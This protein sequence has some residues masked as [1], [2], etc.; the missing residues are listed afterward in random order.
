V[1]PRIPEASASQD[2]GSTP[3]FR[4]NAFISYS[5][6]VDGKLA[7]AL[8][9]A[10]QRFAKPWYR[11]RGLR[12]FRDD[13]SLS[14]SPALWSSI[15]QALDASEFFV[16]LASPEAAQSR[17][18][19]KE[20]EYWREHKARDH[21]LV[22]LTDGEIVWDETCRSFR[23]DETSLPRAIDGVFG[24][25]PR[26][27]D[28]RWARKEEHL[29]LRD[30]RFRNDIAD[31]AATLH[32]WSKDEILGEDVRQHRRTLRIA[33][34][35]MILLAALLVTAVLGGLL[36]V[37]QRNQAQ[38]ERDVASSR[39]L[40][41]Q[42]VSD[43]DDSLPR[44]LL[45]SLEA[46]RVRDTTEARSA[47][48]TALQRPTP[49]LVGFLEGHLDSVTTIDF[50]AD[51]RLFAAGAA[52]GTIRLW[53][54]ARRQPVGPVIPAHSLGVESVAFSPDGKI[55]A[56]AGDLTIKLWDVSSHRK[57]GSPLIDQ[58]EGIE[59]LAFRPDGKTLVSAGDD[60]AIRFW[61]VA[62][63]RQLGAPLRG[64]REGV[65]TVAFSPDGRT[66]ASAGFDGTVRM[67]DVARRRQA[68]PAL[69][70]HRSIVVGVAFSPDGT[71][72]AS[73][74]GDDTVRLWDV[75]RRRQLGKPLARLSEGVSSVAF[76]PDG[77]RLAAGGDSGTIMVWDV[78]Q[79][80]LLVT[81]VSPPG[82]HSVS[83]SAD[84]KTIASA[85]LSPTI[86]L[87]SVDRPRRLGSRLIGHRDLI[88]GVAFSP[89]GD[90]LA[91]SSSDHRIRFWD[92]QRARPLGKPV[93][94]SDH[95][96][97]VR[98]VAFMPNGNSLMSAGDP[99]TIR[100]WDVE[101]QRPAGAPLMVGVETFEGFAFSSDRSR[102]AYSTGF[103]GIS[104]WDVARRRRV[105]APLPSGCPELVSVLAFS[106]D[107]E[108][109]VSGCDT[110]EIRFWDLVHHRQLG[111]PTTGHREG[112]HSL[113]FSPDGKTL[114]S[115]STDRTIRFW[116]VAERRQVGAPLVEHRDWINGLAFSPDG[117]LLA[118]GGSDSMIRLWDV[119]RRQTLGLPLVGHPAPVANVVFSPDGTK[120]ASFSND[121][122]IILWD[123]DLRSWIN[124]A[125]T[126]ASRNLTQ[127][128]W[129]RFVGSSRP[130]ERTCQ[131][132]PAG[133]GAPA[134]A[135]SAPVHATGQ[136]VQEPPAPPSR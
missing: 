124:H 136:G 84:G 45:L 55:I 70:G 63:R 125:C 110:G 121:S 44:A 112:V 30:A 77:K 67:W 12:V 91:S 116:D 118:S 64:D 52:D 59:D 15:V 71:K 97:V 29:T 11:L 65:M 82:A 8:Q 35:A 98:D 21:M 40:A 27:T 53:D 111:T 81:L 92:V 89:M 48:L 80:R 24:E 66:L 37:N 61:N 132:H 107:A 28:L 46:L 42:A 76:S 96:L 2:V 31:I 103:E 4:Y 113:T 109:L 58:Q 134:D 41:A 101:R 18:V 56:S 135:P 26:Y 123:L 86:K 100:R 78:T 102:I 16:L 19:G 94:I 47:L 62:R 119:E 130:Y 57:I 23:W 104:V 115:G 39:Y 83:F 13:A 7:P 33:G 38:A 5:R 108:T 14:A 131:D 129:E 128:E 3:K 72:V 114:V 10:L 126:L 51:G 133:V 74:G 117:T 50:S 106:P 95:D 69:E 17:W 87:W 122:T 60:G 127:E 85:G 73:V 105:G 93:R 43:V 79:R 1:T 9:S 75:T 20:V 36:A 68:G 54:V 120:L 22:V 99:G 49:E 90:R 34:A 25:E 32:G 88:T 6:A